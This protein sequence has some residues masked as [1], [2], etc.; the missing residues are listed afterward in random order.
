MKNKLLKI[1]S[2]IIIFCVVTGLCSCKLTHKEIEGIMTTNRQVT[3]PTSSEGFAEKKDDGATA[4]AP[5]GEKAIIKCFNKALDLFY[6]KDIEFTR[7]KTTKLES[8]SA[9]TLASVSGATASYTSM[10]QSACGD[11]MG[12]GSLESAYYFG[13]DISFA[14]SIKPVSEVLVK[15]CSATAEGSNIKLNIVYNPFM[16][17]INDSIKNL[18]ADYMTTSDF[19]KRIADYGA[20]YKDAKASIDSIKVSALID[21]STRTFVSLKIEY[22][23]KFSAK[24]ISFDYVSGGPLNGT[25][26]TVIAYGGFKEK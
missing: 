2:L 20:D 23:T 19:I 26:K 13:D 1:V 25:T 3:L 14:F 15:K 8:Y 21:Y 16:G 5:E 11:M 24:E 12:V 10:L 7:K 6:Q 9:G 4:V 17:D 22:I 18:T